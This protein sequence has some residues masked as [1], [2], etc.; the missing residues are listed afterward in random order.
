MM[1]KNTMAVTP[2]PLHRGSWFQTLKRV[3][4][5][6]REE[7]PKSLWFKTLGETVYRRAVLIERPLHES[8]PRGTTRLPVTVGLLS[9]TDVDAYL[10]F[11]PETHPSEVHSRL[12]AGHLCFVVRHEG[13]MISAAWIATGQV[14]ID[15]LACEIRL[16]ADE[17]YLYESFTSPEYRGQNI[18][19]VRATQEAKL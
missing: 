11:C 3:A 15:Y 12:E 18:P 19:A 9:E 1:K 10:R 5:I 17:A 7:G 2:R 14:W 4:A 13:R 16:A 6:W 8:I